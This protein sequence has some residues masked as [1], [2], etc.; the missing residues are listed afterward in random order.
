MGGVVVE[1][2]E[3]DS[4][5]RCAPRTIGSRDKLE[6]GKLQLY[7]K[8][9]IIIR[10]VQ[11]LCPTSLPAIAGSC[12]SLHLTSPAQALC[13]GTE[14]LCH[15]FCASHWCATEV[16]S[17]TGLRFYRP[18]RFN[19]VSAVMKGLSKLRSKVLLC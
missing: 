5:K 16:S 3:L 7:I 19:S 10:V 9:K 6:Q 2:M 13:F 12:P 15:I 11:S 8:K 4:S 17:L 18:S 1:K 14:S